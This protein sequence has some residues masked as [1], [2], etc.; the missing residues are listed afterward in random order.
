MLQVPSTI[1]VGVGRK[2]C[3]TIRPSIGGN[4][5]ITTKFV[6][7]SVHPSIGGNFG[8]TTKFVTPSVHP[9]IGGNFGIT[10]IEQH[11]EQTTAKLSHT[12]HEIW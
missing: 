11:I 12:C 10:K 6:T 9:S 5:G 8:I 1:M 7:P 3:D 2:V 4:F